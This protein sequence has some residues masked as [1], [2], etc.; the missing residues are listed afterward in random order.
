LRVAII[1][2]LILVYKA[3]AQSSAL[4][5]AD[6]LYALGNY[7][8]AI[9]EYA[10]VGSQKSS[11]QIARAYNAI[12]TYDK[13]IAQYEDLVAKDSNQIIAHF[14]LGKLYVKVKRFS[15]SQLVFENLIKKND[16]NPE[17]YY[18]LGRSLQELD[19]Y[20]EAMLAYENTIV[21]DSTHLRSLFQLGKFYVGTREKNIAL[22]YIDQGL[23]FYPKD[24]SL[25]NLKALAYFNNGEHEEAIPLFEELITLGENKQHI[26]RKLAY[27]YFKLWEFEK[28]K[29]NYTK[30]LDFDATRAEAFFSLGEVFWK[31]KQLDSA[32]IYIKKSIEEQDPVLNREYSALASLAKQQH[33]IKTSFEYY[34]KAYQED[35]SNTITYY[36]VCVLAD[37][38]YKDPKVKLEYYERLVKK[39]GKENSYFL[40]FAKKRITALKEEI[41]YAVD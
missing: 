5:V 25:I 7:T 6:S 21:L 13:A 12:G 33:K 30:L 41:H 29:I 10:K 3:E 17:Y 20:K 4:P 18:Y 19:E 24:V 34:K 1:L 14:E 27:S 23:E 9:N 22:T 40:S 15:K 2:F 16:D 11:L 28:A 35:T 26:Y 39:L 38:Y 8:N 31:Q 32:V 36:Q 37:E